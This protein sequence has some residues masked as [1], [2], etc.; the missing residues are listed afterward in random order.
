M[1][2]LHIFKPVDDAQRLVTERL[3]TFDSA[4]QRIYDEWLRDEKA[5][6]E[7]REFLNSLEGI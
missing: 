2:D 1:N 4:E 7:Y 3:E 6:T 5:Q